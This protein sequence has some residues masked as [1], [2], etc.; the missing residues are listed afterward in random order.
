MVNKHGLNYIT[1][2]FAAIRGKVD[3]TFP[4]FRVCHSAD[5]IASS[6]KNIIYVLCQ[7]NLCNWLFQICGEFPSRL[8][9]LLLLLRIRCLAVRT[10]HDLRE[11][12]TEILHSHLIECDIH[13]SVT[14]AG[15]YLP[16]I[17][18]KTSF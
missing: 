18:H 11:P 5:S 14:Q 9:W 4:H 15:K 12:K 6:N 7:T 16:I 10:L 1:I 2:S 3:E 13:E 8:S 17:P